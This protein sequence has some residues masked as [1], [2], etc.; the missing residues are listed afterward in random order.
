MRRNTRTCFQC[1]KPEHFVADCR[2]NVKNKKNYKHNS[3]TDGKN[4]SR[5]DHEHKNKGKHKDE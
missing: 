1:G 3:K 4:R 5:R 2:E